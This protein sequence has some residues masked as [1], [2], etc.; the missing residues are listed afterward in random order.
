MSPLWL[1]LTL[2]AARFQKTL[3]I[4]KMVEF[5]QVEFCQTMPLDLRK[6]SW[7]SAQ[8]VWSG[9]LGFPLQDD[10]TQAAEMLEK[11]NH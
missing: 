2:K 3:I 9:D 4:P 11:D 8:Y 6:G 1:L 10:S 7:T 5:C